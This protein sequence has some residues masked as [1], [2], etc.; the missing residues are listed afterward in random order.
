MSLTGLEAEVASNSHRDAIDTAMRAESIG[1]NRGG[2]LAM[3]SWHVIVEIAITR[4]VEVVAQDQQE[5]ERLALH[6]AQREFYGEEYVVVE[7]EMH[8]E[9]K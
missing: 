6:K 5:A 2:Q 1:E 4:Q 3:N 7:C 9:V 8:G